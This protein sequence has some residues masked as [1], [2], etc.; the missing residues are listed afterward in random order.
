MLLTQLYKVYKSRIKFAMIY[1]REAHPTDGWTF[2]EGVMAKIVHSYTPQAHFNIPDPQTID[3]RRKIADKCQKTLQ[4]EMITYVDDMDNLANRLYA[5]QPTRL[6]L[7]GT[8]GKV[9][10][11]GKPGPLGFSP[12]EFGGAIKQY[13]KSYA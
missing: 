2:G 12:S 11:A 6:Y 10:Y 9:V 7:I 8:D 4:Y 13:L 5:A 1:I 3:E